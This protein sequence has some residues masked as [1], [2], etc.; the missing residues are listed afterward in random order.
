MAEQAKKRGV[1]CVEIGRRYFLF[2]T[3]NASFETNALNSAADLKNGVVPCWAIREALTSIEKGV[4]S[5]LIDLHS[6]G[7]EVRILP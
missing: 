5:V 3:K 1:R 7:R 2:Y 6:E 4:T